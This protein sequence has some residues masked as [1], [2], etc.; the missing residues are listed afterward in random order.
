MCLWIIWCLVWCGEINVVSIISLV[1]IIKFVILLMW[2]IFFLWLVLLKLRL[3]YNLWWILLLFSRYVLMLSLCNVFFSVLVI[4]DLL[5]LERL[6]NYSIILWWLW[7]SLCCCIVIG[8]LCQTMFLLCS[9]IIYFLV[10]C[11]C[12]SVESGDELEYLILVWMY[13]I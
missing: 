5:D 1:L 3:L 4:V 11:V 8:W 12:F 13:W 6:V 2:W 10:N 7:C 9:V